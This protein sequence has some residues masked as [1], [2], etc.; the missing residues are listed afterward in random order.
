MDSR[1]HENWPSIGSLGYASLR[2]ISNG[3]QSCFHEHW[4]ISILDCDQQVYEQKR[5]QIFM[6]KT[7]NLVTTK[8]WLPMQGVPLRQHQSNNQLHHYFLLKDVRTSW[9]TEVEWFSCDRLCQQESLF[10]SS[11]EDDDVTIPSIFTT[12]VHH[13]IHSGLIAVGTNRYSSPPLIPWATL[14][15]EHTTTCRN[16]ERHSQRQRAE[17]SRMLDIGSIWE[18]LKI[19]H[20]GQFLR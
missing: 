8:R 2:S 17:C 4:W 12:L 11:L 5:W 18:M 9:P 3:N 16:Y 19:Q 7:E 13:M 14:K 10:R 15:K 6:K 20:T 1:K